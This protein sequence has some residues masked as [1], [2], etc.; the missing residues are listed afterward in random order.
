[1][2]KREGEEEIWAGERMISKHTLS[3]ACSSVV[4][5]VPHQGELKLWFCDNA[6]VSAKAYHTK[7]LTDPKRLVFD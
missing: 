6:E 2:R 3:L 7:S 4:S 5:L 1:M